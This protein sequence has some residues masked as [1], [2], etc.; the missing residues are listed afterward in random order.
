[1]R[2]LTFFIP[3]LFLITGCDNNPDLN[4]TPLKTAEWT[5]EGEEQPYLFTRTSLDLKYLPTGS[6]VYAYLSY[7]DQRQRRLGIWS[8]DAD[9]QTLHS[10]VYTDP[11][12]GVP[13]TGDTQPLVVKINT[14][15]RLLAFVD[16]ELLLIGYNG[17]FYHLDHV[18]ALQNEFTWQDI[19]YQQLTLLAHDEQRVCLVGRNDVGAALLC[20]APDGTLLWQVPLAITFDNIARPNL[21]GALQSDGTLVTAQLSGNTLEL[22]GYDSSGTE[23]WAQQQAL[24][25]MPTR[26]LSSMIE[27]GSHLLLGMLVQAEDGADGFDVVQFSSDG[28]FETE[29]TFPVSELNGDNRRVRLLPYNNAGYLLLTQ[30]ERTDVHFGKNVADLQMTAF[31]GESVWKK[32][33]N[34][35]SLGTERTHLAS[36]QIEVNDGVIS[37]LQNQQSVLLYTPVVIPVGVARMVDNLLITELDGRGE[38]LNESVIGRLRYMVEYEGGI[39]QFNQHGFYPLVMATNGADYFVAGAQTK[40]PAEEPAI[41]NSNHQLGKFA[42]TQ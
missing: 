15:E 39:Y 21:M 22:T 37:V 12:I 36:L 34:L 42:L 33:I 35:D 32:S 40:P 17:S 28:L 31:S 23:L 10:K 29:F 6:L 14:Q 1:M 8:V 18:G 24:D 9:G 20:M 16:N 2:L 3:V 41:Y 4:N 13:V 11:F 5:V 7:D 26:I 30:R 19:G 25:V 38:L 27:A